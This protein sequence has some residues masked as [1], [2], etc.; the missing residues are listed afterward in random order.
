M[1][2]MVLRVVPKR[3]LDFTN[4]SSIGASQE[5]VL[6]QG[7][8]VSDWREVSMMVRLHQNSIVSTVGKIELYAYMEGRT[9]EDPGILF[10]SANTLAVVTISN[11]VAAPMYAVSSLG[12]NV[13]AMIKIAARGTRTSS[14]ASNSI[15]A[16]IS[17]DLS[18]KSA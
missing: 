4:V 9:G 10:T 11:T 14:N 16:D 13:G 6:A 5:I 15:K 7:I 1:A 2:G 3:T 8:D 12:S 18:M 17:V